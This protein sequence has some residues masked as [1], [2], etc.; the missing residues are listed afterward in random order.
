MTL[1]ERI[2][3]AVEKRLAV[4]AAAAEG[5]SGQWFM[6]EKGNVYRVEDE[7]RYDDDYQ[8][9]ENK[10][11]VYGYVKSQTEHIADNDPDQ[12]IRD[13]RRDLKMLAEYA[14]YRDGLDVKRDNDDSWHFTGQGYVWHKVIR[15]LA[16]AYEIGVDD[17]DG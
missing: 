4:A 11:V 3:A 10:L 6:D 17:G 5:D 13:C 1:H 12:I 9:E 15:Y 2:S 7:A 8:G 14:K 16:E